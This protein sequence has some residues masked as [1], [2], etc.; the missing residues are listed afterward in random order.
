MSDL[1]FVTMKLSLQTAS[2]SLRL[3]LLATLVC[4]GSSSFSWSRFAG[5]ASDTG[6]KVGLRI[7]SPAAGGEVSNAVHLAE[8]RGMATVDSVPP[9][10]YD[11]MLA[12]DVSGSTN[13][14][15]GTDVDGDGILGIDPRYRS[16]HWWHSIRRSASRSTDTWL[17][18]GL[19]G[20]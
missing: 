10:G 13:E 9:P 1:N 4:A 15:S 14:P 6:P 17:C 2:F 20:P 11:L 12:L 3:L 19:G 5:A 8:V 16:A 18:P 7:E